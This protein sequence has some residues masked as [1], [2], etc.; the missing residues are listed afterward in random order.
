MCDDPGITTLNK[1]MDE[2]AHHLCTDMTNNIKYIVAA[3]YN[4]MTI[5]HK[6][7]KNKQ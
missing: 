2:Q 4:G 5:T 1:Y 6:S 3:I 7:N